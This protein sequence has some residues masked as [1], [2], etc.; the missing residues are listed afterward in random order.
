[1]YVICTVATV[2]LASSMPS[3]VTIVLMLIPKVRNF[4]HIPTGNP[5]L[6]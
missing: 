5:A 1:M 3:Q 6:C 2:C 4:T